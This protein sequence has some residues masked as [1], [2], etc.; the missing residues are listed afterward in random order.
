MPNPGYELCVVLLNYRT[1]NMVLDCL[2]TLA[3]Q[4]NELCAKV[5]VIDNNSP[6]DSTKIIQNWINK[7][8]YDSTVE[9]ACSPHNGGFSS[10]NNFGIRSTKAK[11]YLLLNSD[12]LLRK[13]ALAEMVA[14]ISSDSKI[15]LLGPRLEW[16]NETPQES[17]FRFHRPLSQF[18]ASANTG[19]FTKILNRYE[20]AQRVQPTPRNYEWVSFACVMIRNEVFD[21]IGLLDEKFFM[22]F[23]DVEFCWRAVK[24]GWLIR[25]HPS[26]RVVHLR[27]G[28][29]LVKTNI[30]QRKRQARYLYES[31]TRYFF[32]TGGRLGLLASN[33]FWTLGWLF[34]SLR[35]LL[36]KDFVSPACEREWKDIWINFTNP[37]SPYIHPENYK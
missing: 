10:G 29:S 36:Q 32:L 33:I 25:N 27:G 16:P 4:A 22:Y 31:R 2:E 8:S 26:A 28:S 5:V 17:C 13:G 15:G 11:Y 23:E 21:Q 1:P 34:A 3:S 24:A 19:I 18:V 30:A 9:L 6:D 37:E 35:A 20:V 14:A 12:T 7:S